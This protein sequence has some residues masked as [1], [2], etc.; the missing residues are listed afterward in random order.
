MKMKM[1]E[2]KFSRYMVLA[3]ILSVVVPGVGAQTYTDRQKIVRSFP[4]N[5]ETRLDVTNKY[6]TVHVVPWKKDSVHIEID[7]FIKSSSTSKLE[8][9]KK[10]VDFEF[11]DTKYYIIA[12]TD[13]GGRGGSFFSD[14]KEIIPS[15]NQVKIDYTVH[16]PPSLNIT[17]SNKY[18]DIYI[19]DMKGS[20]SVNLSN[21]DIKA[22]SL[23]GE[24]NISLNFGNGIINELNNAKLNIAYADIEIQKAKQL[25]IES[26]SSKIR[27][28]EAEILKTIS[29]RDKFTVS[30][31]DNLFGE[32]WFSD[33]WLYRLGEEINYNPKYG[34]LK[35]DSIA[36]QFS[37]I[38]INTENADLRMIFNR[39]TSYQL[40]VLKHEDVV[41]QLPD[42]YG[43]LEVI[44]QEVEAVHLK[45]MVGPNPNAGSQV[46]I[47][48]PKKCIINIQIR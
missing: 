46:K 1:L 39:K 29:R 19:D 21:G 30:R 27:I 3:A 42:E 17:I 37:F 24:S 28:Y 4:A 47:K 8:K 16:V 45:G 23:K 7:L 15:K 14:L 33:I 34:A 43:K 40:E 44:D 18:G 6:G 12:R 10:S 13:F 38:N 35:V 25:N 36:N 22:N 48:A 20:V 9:L 26:K 5:A 41:L 31:V 32:S 2:L 11:T